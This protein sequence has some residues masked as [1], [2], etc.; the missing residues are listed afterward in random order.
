[1]PLIHLEGPLL[2]V[3]LIDDARPVVL[4]LAVRLRR[5]PALHAQQA[6][7]EIHRPGAAG[8]EAKH[9]ATLGEHLLGVF[10]GVHAGGGEE[11]DP[12]QVHHHLA[13]AHSAPQRCHQRCTR[14]HVNGTADLQED[15]GAA[16]LHSSDVDSDGHAAP[17]V[18]GS[19]PA[20]L[21]DRSPPD[22]DPSARPVSPQLDRDTARGQHVPGPP[23]VLP[24]ARRL[25]HSPLGMLVP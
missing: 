25:N 7:H 20:Q 2:G 5:P 17:T 9:A 6:Q 4:G 3:E 10:Q 8:D 23:A 15:A 22:V 11:R 12:G 1:M 16:L 14:G 21:P 24:T 18:P 13:V 19:G